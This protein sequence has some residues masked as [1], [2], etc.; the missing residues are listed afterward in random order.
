MSAQERWDQTFAKLDR[1]CPAQRA[2]ESHVDFLRRLSRVGRKYIPAGEPI[3]QV[4][5]DHTLPDEVVP[6]FSE[7]MRQAV[8]RNL[9]RTDNMRPGDVR[10]V[11]QIDENTGQ[12]IRTWIGPRVAFIDDMGM[13]RKARLNRELADASQRSKYPLNRADWAVTYK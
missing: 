1:S 13:I 12:K 4:R 3:A 9:Y 5:F 2:D 7:Q 10:P 11:M 8:E 6:K